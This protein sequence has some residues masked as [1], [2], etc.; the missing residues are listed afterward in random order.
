MKVLMIHVGNPLL[1]SEVA[2][3]GDFV[4]LKVLDDGTLRWFHK[5][6]VVNATSQ[7]DS[8]S[9]LGVVIEH[10]VL[11]G[12]RALFALFLA[13]LRLRGAV[14]RGQ[15]DL[16]HVLW[17]STTGLVAVLF[18][19]VPTVLSLCGSDLYGSVDKRGRI[20]WNGRLSR[21]LSLLAARW[22]SRIIVKSEA[23]RRALPEGVRSKAV[24]VPNGVDMKCFYPDSREVSRRRLGWSPSAKIAI[25]FA[26]EGG[27]SAV[28]DI[29]LAQT[30]AT[31]VEKRIPNF[32]FRLISAVPHGELPHY[33]NA[34]DIMLLTSF[35]EGSNNSLKEAISCGLPVVSVDCG[36]SRERL[37]G[38]RNCHVCEGR[39]PAVLAERAIEALRD[40]RRVDPGV[41]VR[42][43]SLLA[44][45]RR[46]LAVYEEAVR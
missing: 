15:F 32:E 13:G 4:R 23:M 9:D 5:R 25:F 38:L 16:V 36:D 24:V 30:A 42:S 22:V 41:N 28:K 29:P 40:G 6:E 19:P 11:S 37:A 44:I 3:G 20:T 31:L 21:A 33:Y 10:G 39:D 1:D 7:M 34:A 43:L 12:R 26:G 35:H 46:V 8:L 14:S 2:D 45:A 18:S 27:G 17:G